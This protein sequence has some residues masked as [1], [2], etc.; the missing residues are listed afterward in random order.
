MSVIKLLGIFY[1]LLLR[2]VNIIE[3][4]NVDLPQTKTNEVTFLATF[5][6]YLTPL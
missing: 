1:L 6:M 3:G 5:K 4:L 2:D